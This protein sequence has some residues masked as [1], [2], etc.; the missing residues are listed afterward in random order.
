MRKG[1][2]I[3]SNCDNS[4]FKIDSL[5]YAEFISSYD[6]DLYSDSDVDI[7]LSIAF[8]DSTWIDF[9]CGV[10]IINGDSTYLM[11]IIKSIIQKE[12]FSNI[13]QNEFVPIQKDVNRLRSG[14]YFYIRVCKLTRKEVRKINTKH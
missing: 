10:E 6:I 12:S 8:T 9:T 11:P 14:P 13:M 7:L 4:N 3:Y 2:V 5:F 1:K